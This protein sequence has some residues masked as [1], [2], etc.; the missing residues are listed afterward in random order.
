MIKA[1]LFDYGGI[2]VPELNLSRIRKE[3]SWDTLALRV[4]PRIKKVNKYVDRF[5]KGKF[6]FSKFVKKLSRVAKLDLSGILTE[7]LI[8]DYEK[9]SK[10]NPDMVDLTQRLKNKGYTIGLLSNTVQVHADINRSK[11]NYSLFDLIILSCDVKCRKP[12]REIYEIA[13]KRLNLE[14]KEILF[15]DNKIDYLVPAERLGMKVE[16][17]ENSYQITERLEEILYNQKLKK[18]KKIK[19]KKLL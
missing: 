12:D 3:L 14:P 9:K 15:I 18:D 4:F 10:L 8:T 1:V 2:F 11:G 7:I 13:V 5:E 6:D 19:A 17:F 16:L